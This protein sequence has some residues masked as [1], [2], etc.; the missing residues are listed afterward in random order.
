MRPGWIGF[1]GGGEEGLL[2]GPPGPLQVP[3]RG[4]PLL[5]RRD[6]AAAGGQAVE[7]RAQRPGRRQHAVDV[8]GPVIGGVDHVDDP[9]LA[10]V[11]RTTGGSRAGRRPR[12][13]HRPVAGPI[14]CGRTPAR[15]R[16]AGSP[17]RARWRTSGCAGSR[18]SCAASPTP[19]PSRRRCRPPGTAGGPTPDQGGGRR[20]Q[21]GVRGGAGD[22]A[23]HRDRRLGRPVEHV[24]REVDEDRAPVRCHGGGRRLGHDLRDV[25]G[26]R[27][28]RGRL[29]DRPDD[30]DVVE[31]LQRPACPIWPGRP[32]RRARSGAS[33]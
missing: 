12:P 33:R 10:E 26:R 16:P 22:R 20:D 24:D 32:G 13:P 29:R 19:P 17:C 4:D 21:I 31:L 2:F 28:R 30:R 27:H 6:R 8:G 18:R 23:A 3:E 9:G 15:G 5:V 11:A 1:A 14:G 25:P 7:H